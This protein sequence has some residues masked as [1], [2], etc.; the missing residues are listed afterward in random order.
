MHVYIAH[1]LKKKKKKRR[2]RNDESNAM[3]G[4]VFHSYGTF[5]RMQLH[6]NH[7]MISINTLIRTA[8]LFYYCVEN[9]ILY[10]FSH[11]RLCETIKKHGWPMSALLGQSTWKRNLIF[12]Y[13]SR[14]AHKIDDHQVRFSNTRPVNHIG[15]YFGLDWF[16]E[17][18][19]VLYSYKIPT[20]TLNEY[21]LWLIIHIWRCSATTTSVPIS[22]RTTRCVYATTK[23]TTTIANCV[24]HHPVC[25]DCVVTNWFN[26]DSLCSVTFMETLEELMQTNTRQLSLLNKE[27]RFA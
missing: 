19:I 27:I 13:D 12:Y 5:Y 6:C 15:D 25:M 8:L 17:Y 11:T 9:L 14:T 18:S 20:V 24:W 7:S 2:L 26:K 4:N 16:N 3:A 1:G 21:I 10:R 23:I 22:K